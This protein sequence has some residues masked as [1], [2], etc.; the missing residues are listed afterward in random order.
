MRSNLSLRT[1]PPSLDFAL[2]RK[3]K[4][5]FVGGAEEKGAGRKAGVGAQR[6]GGG[7]TDGGKTEEE[8]GAGWR[9][10]GRAAA[11][12]AAVGQREVP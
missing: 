4:L 11:A 1:F 7:R 9:A 10:E 2:K 12:A 8:G 5:T 6:S 3:Q